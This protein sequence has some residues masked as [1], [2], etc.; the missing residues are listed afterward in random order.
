MYHI[1][2]DVRAKKSADLIADAVITL[3]QQTKFTDISI[4]AVQRES[5]VSRSTFY[6]LFDTTVDVLAYRCD[7]MVNEISADM[8]KFDQQGLHESQIVFIQ[9]CMAHVELLQALDASGHTAILRDA[10]RRSLP[11]I[12]ARLPIDESITT[13][14]AD[15]INSMLVDI[16]PS[17]MFVWLQHGRQENAET[18]FNQIK[19]ATQVLSA[20]YR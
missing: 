18:V 11:Q 15:Y 17:A 6:R 3:S 8:N 20:L 9:E 16:L 10:H 7:Q 13:D 1:A 5:S 19:S 12:I 2:N 4:A 14:T